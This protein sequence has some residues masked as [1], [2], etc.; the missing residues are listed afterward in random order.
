MTPPRAGRA[1]GTGLAGESRAWPNGRCGNLSWPSCTAP[2]ES[3]AWP[4]GRC[5]NP[6][7]ASTRGGHAVL[8]AKNGPP[9]RRVL[10]RRSRLVSCA[11]A[12]LPAWRNGIGPDVHI[13]TGI[14]VSPLRACEGTA[15]NVHIG[16]E[17]VA[18][19]ARP[20]DGKAA[21]VHIAANPVAAP[22][23]RCDGPAS[24]VHIGARSVAAPR[25]RCERIVPNVHIA[26]V[27][28]APRRGPARESW[29]VCA[30]RRENR[31]E[32]AFLATG[33]APMC[34]LPASPSRRRA[35]YPR[36]RRAPRGPRDGRGANVHIARVLVARLGESCD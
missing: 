1:S 9:L 7:P 12:G 18:L 35:H 14:V 28:V 31:G 20:C 4:N 26:R 11:A 30:A 29:G 32:C 6:R 17:C 16:L 5:G 27:S 19:P 2:W 23:E 10:E 13:G 21:N 33:P 34:T 36:I 22:L 24:N 8:T 25:E 15:A 3:R